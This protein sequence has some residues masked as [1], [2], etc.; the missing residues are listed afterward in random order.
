MDFNIWCGEEI[1]WKRIIIDL[2]DYRTKADYSD[3]YQKIASSRKDDYVNEL[4]SL[5]TR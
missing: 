4:Q 3:I 2:L 5:L 1:N